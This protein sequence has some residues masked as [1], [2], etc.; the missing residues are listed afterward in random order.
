MDAPLR[1]KHSKVS[2]SLYFDHLYM[3]VLITAV[4]VNTLVSV[5]NDKSLGGSLIL[6]PVMKVRAAGPLLRP[7][8]YLAA[9]CWPAN[10]TSCGFHQKVWLFL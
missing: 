9:G 7:G 10:S 8:T 5:Y 1:A 2:Y 3:S 4:I 6:C